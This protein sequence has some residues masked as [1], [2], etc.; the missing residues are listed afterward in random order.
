MAP[1]QQPLSFLHPLS[2]KSTALRY[3]LR[4]VSHCITLPSFKSGVT[5]RIAPLVEQSVEPNLL[6]MVRG[7]DLHRQNFFRR[8]CD[9]V[10]TPRHT[11][12]RVAQ[13]F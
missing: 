3:M 13:H 4:F 5:A 12:K 11:A 10:W 8:T 2:K 9:F 1:R 6:R 7:N